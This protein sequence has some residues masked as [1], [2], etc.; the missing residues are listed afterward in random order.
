M[1]YFILLVKMLSD[2]PDA[3]TIPLPGARRN[4]DI[5]EPSYLFLSIQL[6]SL[7]SLKMT[8]KYNLIGVPEAPRICK[9]DIVSFI[10]KSGW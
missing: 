6:F 5:L 2:T 9:A 3:Q 1:V 10:S 7:P 8:A 4:S